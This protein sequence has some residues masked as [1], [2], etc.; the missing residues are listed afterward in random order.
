MT[1]AGLGRRVHGSHR[2][3]MKITRSFSPR[4]GDLRAS[5]PCAT[6]KTCTDVRCLPPDPPLRRYLGTLQPFRPVPPPSRSRRG[7]PLRRPAEPSRTKFSTAMV[8]PPH[9]STPSTWSSTHSKPANV[10][11]V[12]PTPPSLVL[13]TLGGIWAVAA[14]LCRVVPRP[15][16][17]SVYNLMARNRY[18][19][20]GKFDA[21]PLSE[22]PP[23]P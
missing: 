22:S 18:P 21:C 5:S 10:S 7:L 23:P 15:R 12:A 19:V 6:M 11:W 9:I 8:P 20:F 4:T 13:A 16:H 2:V 3:V 1:A 14:A 17:D